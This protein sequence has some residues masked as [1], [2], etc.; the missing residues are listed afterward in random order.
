VRLNGAEALASYG[1]DYYAG[2]PAVAL[3]HFGRGSVIYVGTM[4]DN[5]LVE[6]VVGK[7]LE[8]AKIA[9]V[10]ENV[11]SIEITS[12][13]QDGCS[14]LFLLNHSLES[15]SVTLGKP[16]RDLL[17]HDRKVGTVVV[18]AKDVL[19]LLEESF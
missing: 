6:G 9:P 12:R 16:Y 15:Q 4:G 11:G 17:T 13:V 7:A 1:E 14:L 19:L 10:P 2:Q 8:L 5:A 3:N 18:P